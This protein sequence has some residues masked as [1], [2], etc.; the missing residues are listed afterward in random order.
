VFDVRRIARAVNGRALGYVMI[1][2]RGTSDNAARYA[3]YL[4]GERLGLPVALAAPSLE[5]LYG[6]AAV[7]RRGDALVIGISQS[8]RSPDVVG[9]LAAARAAGAPT[10]AITNDAGSPLAR[11][12]EF[13][14]ALDAGPERSVAATKTYTASLAALAALVAELR[15]DQDDRAALRRV[16]SMLQLALD[17]AFAVVEALDRHADAPHVVAVGRGYHYATV[18]EI[19]LKVRELTATVAEGF[20]S[21]DLMHGPIAAIAP[22]TPAIVVATRGK[23]LASVLETADALRRRGAQPIMISDA[24]SADLPVPPALPEWLSP[25]VAVVPGQVLALRRAVVGGHAID[26]PAGLTKVTETY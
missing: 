7:P 21:A 20:S 13:L 3:Q 8:G 24:P 11:T 16:P 4:F 18:M 6:A 17:D 5:T 23:A 9:V 19:A 25:L 26:Q 14:V 15:D 1:A 2:A 12:A 22:G 10:V